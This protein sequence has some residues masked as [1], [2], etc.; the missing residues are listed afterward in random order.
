MRTLLPILAVLPLLS[1]CSSHHEAQQA[2]TPAKSTFLRAPQ[3]EVMPG[4]NY[5]NGADL[6]A[7]G[8]FNSNP[9]AQRFV[10]YMVSKHGYDRNQLQYWLG[11]A[12]RLDSVIAL[13]ERQAPRPP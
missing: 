11:H 2:A 3:A 1:A 10:D 5:A 12:K 4:Q 7:S 6:F 9:A 13:M 8:D